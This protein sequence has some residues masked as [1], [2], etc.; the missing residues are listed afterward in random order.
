MIVLLEISWG[1]KVNSSQY[2]PKSLLLGLS[3]YD[4]MEICLFFLRSSSS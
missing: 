3:K 2:I 4:D 1:Y